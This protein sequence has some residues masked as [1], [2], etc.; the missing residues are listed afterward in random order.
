MQNA[1]YVGLQSNLKYLRLKTDWMASNER[2]AWFKQKIYTEKM[3]V[4]EKFVK[5]LPPN[6]T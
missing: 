6:Y 4:F 2:R 3:K 5:R 1:L